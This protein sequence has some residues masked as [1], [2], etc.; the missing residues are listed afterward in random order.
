LKW[1]HDRIGLSEAPEADAIA[2]PTAAPQP[3]T[4]ILPCPSGSD[5]KTVPATKTLDRTSQVEVLP[6]SHVVA[7]LDGT[8]IVVA[9]R[10]AAPLSPGSLAAQQIS[11]LID[12]V[13]RCE[14]RQ[15]GGALS[16]LAS[17]NRAMADFAVVV[18]SGGALDVYLYGAVTVGFDTGAAPSELSGAPGRVRTHRS[19]PVPAVATVVTVDEEGRR[20]PDRRHW[21]GVYTLAVGTVPGRGAVIWTTRP[22]PAREAPEEDVTTR[23]DRDATIRIG[24]LP[25]RRGT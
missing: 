14:R 25:Q 11:T 18:R 2:A 24:P 9:H 5:E 6:G 12:T 19:L 3:Q 7:N 8:V 21:T 10:D 17:T 15:L 16:V 22:I 23:I 13:R 20:A 4:E 1:L